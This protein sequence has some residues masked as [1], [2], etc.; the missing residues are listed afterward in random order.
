MANRTELQSTVPPDFIRRRIL[1]VE[2]EAASRTAT[3]RYLQF[4]GHEV[5]EAA[6][7]DESFVKAESLLPEILICDWQLGGRRDGTDVAQYMQT[8]YGVKV[9]F[10]TAYALADLRR[11]IHG[12]GVIAC[13]RKPI[14]LATLAAVLD[15][16]DSS[17]ILH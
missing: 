16:V 4:R 2:D 13:L 7:V 14:S 3:C 9:I 6:T 8:R 1:I 12:M 5:A 11:K 10:V 17:D 15:A